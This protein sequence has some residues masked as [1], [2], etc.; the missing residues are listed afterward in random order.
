MR[1]AIVRLA[2][3]FTV[4]VLMPALWAQEE[5]TVDLKLPAGSPEAGRQV[6]LEMSCTSCHAV[7]GE[8]DF[9]QPVSANRGPTLGAYQAKKGAA[10]IGLSIFDPSHDISATIRTKEDKL[11]PMPDFTRVITV[12]QFLDLVAYV[13]SLPGS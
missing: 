11:S 6:F 10:E 13:G 8:K 12:R 5:K 3:A 2:V 9:P 1:Q 7:A 4:F